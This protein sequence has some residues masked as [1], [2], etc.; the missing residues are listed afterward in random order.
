MTNELRERLKEF[1]D[2]HDVYVTVDEYPDR[3]VNLM[4]LKG[5]SCVIRG[6]NVDQLDNILKE[7][8]KELK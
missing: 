7:M 5:H 8:L 2:S 6:L 4:M 1:G 3:P